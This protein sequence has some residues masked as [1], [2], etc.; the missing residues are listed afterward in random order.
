MKFKHLYL[1]LAILGL[2][3]TWYFNIQFYLTAEDISI[4]NFIALTKTTFPAQ[5]ITADL[6]VVVIT[7]LIWVVYES[8]HLKIRY[9]WIVIP[10]TFLIAIAFSFPLYLYMRANRLEQINRINTLKEF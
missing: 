2:G 4:T 8:L 9:W 5:F 7:F 6:T 10:L 3:Y 1:F